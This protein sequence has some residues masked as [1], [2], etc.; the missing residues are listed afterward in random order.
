[1]SPAV[2]ALFKLI[3]LIVGVLW[4]LVIAQVVMSWLVHFQ[5]LNLRQPLVSQIWYFLNRLM[6]PIYRPIRRFL[7][8]MGGIDIAPLILIFVLFFVRELVR[9][10]YVSMGGV[11]QF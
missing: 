1:M 11:P 5:V 2:V 3:Y 7:P 9:G 6:E 8:P 4:T 10:Y